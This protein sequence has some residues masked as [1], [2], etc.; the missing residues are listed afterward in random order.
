MRIG[1][2]IRVIP[3]KS[4]GFLRADDLRDD[5]FFHFSCVPRDYRPGNWEPGQEVEFELNE[6]QKMEGG[7]L[8]ATLVQISKRPQS[9]AIQ[10]HSTKEFIHKH[11][12]NA[13]Q[14]KPRW[15]T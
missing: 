15:R 4:F 5:I 7:D 13:Q 9:Y 14:R 11:H 8:R 12:P 6:I 10:E 3:E 1:K 2:I